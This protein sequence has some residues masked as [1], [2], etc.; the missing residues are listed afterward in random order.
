MVEGWGGGGLGGE[1]VGRV[2]EFGV[3]LVAQRALL[4][5]EELYCAVLDHAL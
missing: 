5:L 3:D 4:L 1:D 2:R